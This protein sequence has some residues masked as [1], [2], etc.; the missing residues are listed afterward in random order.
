MTSYYAGTA[1]T[2]VIGGVELT[3]EFGT[4]SVTGNA[5]CNTFTGP[6]VVA[7]EEIAIGPLASTQRAC[8]DPQLQQQ[9][10]DYLAALQQATTYAVTGTRLDLFRPG[11]TYA[12]TL[13]RS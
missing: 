3:T 12:A 1:V 11:D 10:A 7:G 2:S 9:E 5:G 6:Y 13:E 4:D 8:P